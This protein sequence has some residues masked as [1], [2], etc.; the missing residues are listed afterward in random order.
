MHELRY[1]AEL[2]RD[3]AEVEVWRQ[4]CPIATFVQRLQ[5]WGL[6]NDADLEEIE[7]QVDTEIAAAV[8]Y[9]EAGTWEPVEELTRFVYSDVGT[10]SPTWRRTRA[11][12]KS[13]CSRTG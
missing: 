3:K 4:R 9:A 8:A 7:R 10:L 13:R 1:H 12:L 2:Y 11:L 6:L 5:D